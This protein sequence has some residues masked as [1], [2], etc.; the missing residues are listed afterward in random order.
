MVAGGIVVVVVVNR[1]K[2]SGVSDNNADDY[3][4]ITVFLV[5]VKQL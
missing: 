2:R 5:T 1:W 3:L 4:K